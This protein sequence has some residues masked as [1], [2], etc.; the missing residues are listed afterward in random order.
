MPIASPRTACSTRGD[1][2]VEG[3]LDI[4]HAPGGGSSVLHE[5]GTG[6]SE[7]VRGGG[8]AGQQRA[9][10]VGGGVGQLR[11]SRHRR[12]AMRRPHPHR[13]RQQRSAHVC[14]FIT[15]PEVVGA[16]QG[17]VDALQEHRAML[18]YLQF[19]LHLTASTTAPAS[20]PLLGET[21]SSPPHRGG[22]SPGVAPTSG[23]G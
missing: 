18:S 22:V 2:R 16:T 17:Y 9:A 19:S 4:V 21:S 1:A 23:A 12:G 6:G 15:S 13:V 7:R 11:A 3:T 8:G 14:T 5:R 20:E 10:G